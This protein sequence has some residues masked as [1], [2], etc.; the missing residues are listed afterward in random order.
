[1]KKSAW[2]TE[3]P[4]RNYQKKKLVRPVKYW[5]ATNSLQTGSE[6]RRRHLIIAGAGSNSVGISRVVMEHVI[7]SIDLEAQGGHLLLGGTQ[8]NSETEITERFF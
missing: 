8:H 2:R 7:E 6:E 5:F 1:M 3:K 4:L